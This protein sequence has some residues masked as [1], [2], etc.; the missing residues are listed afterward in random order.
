MGQEVIVIGGGIAGLS[1]AYSL[2]K[3][4][5]KVTVIDEGKIEN[6]T[7]FGNAG[8]L[9]GFEK[10]PL[11]YPG[12]IS[13]TLKRMINGKSPVIIHPQFDTH[14]FRWLWK[15]A[16]NANQERLKKT[17]I[18]FEKYAKRAIDGYNELEKA[19][20]DFDFHQDGG[21]LVFTDKNRYLQKRKSATDS[22][23]YD[24]LSYNEAKSDLGFVKDNIQGIIAL[25]RN[26]RLDPARLMTGLKGHLAAN[27]V[28]F[29]LQE[30]IIN[31]QTTA[32]KIISI[33]SKST[34]YKADTFVLATGANTAL[35]KKLSQN[36]MLVPAKG[37]SITFKIP[38]ELKPKKVVMFNDLF[39][40]ATPRQNDIRITSKLELGTN[41]AT[42]SQKRIDSILENLAPYTHP[43]TPIEPKLWTGFRPLTPNDM[44]LI[45]RDEKYK[46]MVY[47]MGYGWLGMTFGPALGDII[48]RLI[49]EDLDN[50]QSDDILL[51]SGFYQGC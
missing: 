6:S 8:F 40:I 12:V 48:S 22:S 9:S 25:K 5:H 35:A 51:F 11:S 14:L 33:Q 27:G 44:P 20:I 15:F 10:A 13:D 18:L 46:N 28:Q 24:I 42:I 43:F 7:S 36:L 21:L 1:S 17:L 16:T 47:A 4:G 38:D 45:G 39:I 19:G 23:K 26:A 30:E 29:I 49:T 50:H 31:I 32:N 2:L 37:Y 3:A 41:S 34:T